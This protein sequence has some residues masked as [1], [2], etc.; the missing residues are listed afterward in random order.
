MHLVGVFAQTPEE[1]AAGFTLSLSMAQ[2]GG[3]FAKTTQVMVVTLTNISD[4][5]IGD[6]LCSAFGGLYKLSVLY[7]GIQVKESD[8]TR[9]HRK[10]MEA[11]EQGR[12]CS[13]SN[14]GRQISHGEF[15]ADPI[16]YET[17]KPGIYEFTV[18]RKAFLYPTGKSVTIQS[19]KL[20]IK[21]SRA[22]DARTEML[23][24]VGKRTA[25]EMR[26]DLTPW[27]AGK[28]PSDAID[29]ALRVLQFSSSDCEP[30][31]PVLLVTETNPSESV[32]D[33]DGCLPLTF[34][35]S[36]N[37]LV[38]HDGLPMQMDERRWLARSLKETK[39]HPDLC[40][41]APWEEEAGPGGAIRNPL[42]LSYFYD[43]SKSGR[44]EVVLTEETVPS[45]STKSMT[46]KSNT[47]CFTVPEP[48]VSKSR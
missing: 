21:V 6:S 16:Y 11:G 1:Q 37:I 9:R 7:N 8:A 38:T 13:G 43:L 22:E 31:N 26:L 36:I 5:S 19:N 42:Y 23:P 14:P 34:P 47:V 4:R 41:G 2:H 44:Y 39:E 10:D 40:N 46:V 29:F 27:F 18:E 25:S 45:D 32:I 20:K 35:P 15:M 48:V 28:S 33:E 17:D 12:G 30:S 24:G 3:E